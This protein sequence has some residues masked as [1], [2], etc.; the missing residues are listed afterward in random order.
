MWTSTLG[1]V[2]EAALDLWDILW[3]MSEAATSPGPLKSNPAETYWE[4]S[5]FPDLA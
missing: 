3:Q 4:P 1:P 5:S 2:P